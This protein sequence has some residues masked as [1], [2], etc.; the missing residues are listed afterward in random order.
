MSFAPRLAAAPWV[1]AACIAG[2]ATMPALAADK[3]KKESTLGKAKAGAP[4]LTKEQLRACMAQNDRMKAQLAETLPLQGALKKDGD[5][6]AA[7]GDTLKADREKIDTADAAAVQAFNE[8]LAERDKAVEAYRARSAAYN[9]KVEALQA[10]R[11]SY[12]TNCDGHRYFEDEELQ[13]KAGK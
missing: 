10:D 3:P 7:A 5:D 13:I 11:A 8:R 6:L 9:T 4:F 2:L 1:L 12:A